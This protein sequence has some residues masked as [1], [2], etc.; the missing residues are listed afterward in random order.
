MSDW[1]RRLFNPQSLASKTRLNGSFS[2]GLMRQ[3][4]DYLGYTVNPLLSV[5]RSLPRQNADAEFETIH[6]NL[7]YTTVPIKNIDIRS[8]YTYHQRSNNTPI[9]EYFVLRNDSEYQ[10]TQ[11]SSQTIR[12]NLAYGRK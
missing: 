11:L 4:A 6:G 8:S 12:T 1:F 9:D 2:Y 5:D 3:D 10:I 7:V